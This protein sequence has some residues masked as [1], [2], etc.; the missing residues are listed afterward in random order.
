MGSVDE[1]R[2]MEPELDDTSRMV[3]ESHVSLELDSAEVA[4]PISRIKVIGPRHPTI[5]SSA[6]DSHH[7]LPYSRRP[8]VFL[9]VHDKSPRTFKQALNSSK[10]EVWS[11]AIQKELSSM[12]R[13][14]VWEVVDLKPDY[15][16]VG[17]TWVFRTKRNHLNEI[18]EYKARLCA[19]GFTQTPGLDFEKTYAPT[20][21]LN[22][23]RTLISFAALKN[24]HFH[25]VD[26]K[27]TFLNAP[28]TET[29]YLSIPQG[30][31]LD[32]RKTCLCLNK[33]IYGLKQAPLAWYERL[34][35]WL[36]KVGFIACLLDPCVFFR[37]KPTPM[38]LYV[39][40]DNIA[41]F[42][43]DVQPFKDEI[44]REFEIKDVGMA[45]LMLGV[46][47]TH[48]DEFISLDQQHFVESLLKLYGMDKCK[49]VCTPLPPQTHIGP[50]SEDE[51]DKF[52]NLNVS[53]RSA[54]GSI[55]YLSTATRPDLSYAVSS[56]SQ[57]LENPGINHWNSFL[58][59]LKYLNGTQDIGLVYSR[60]SKEGI[61]AY[62]DADWGNCQETRQSV[63]GFLVTF[64]GNLVIWKTRKQPTVSISTAEAKYKALCDLT[65]EIIWFW[66]WCNESALYTNSEPIP[67]HEDNQSCISTV[68]G[69]SNLNQRRMKHIDI[70][71]HFV[72]EFVKNSSI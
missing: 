60:G 66:Q 20:G 46:K 69:D 27:S 16:L 33:A 21:R 56:L 59:V 13:L 58:H 9:S 61:R 34:K 3:D 32:Q 45:D 64:K 53:Y 14:Q 47:I 35:N 2:P 19:Q 44:S 30:L 40:V 24:L 8:K 26:I 71:L 51:L 36:T 48:S 29:V 4:P 43:S 68:E 15:K 54:V 11:S 70:Q 52:K 28:L 37:N 23:L 39:H 49:P 7:I 10:R 42:G 38:W 41:I 72:K 12:N 18:L 5:I 25:Q 31:D 65:S 55:N 57:F 1:I 62:S 17:T 67:V 6:V 50:A 63:T 22:S